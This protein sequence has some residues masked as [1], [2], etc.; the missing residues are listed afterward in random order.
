MKSMSNMF[1]TVRYILL[2]ICLVSLSQ[3]W[4]GDEDMLNPYTEFDPETGFFL[5]IENMPANQQA[6]DSTMATAPVEQ[7][8]TPVTSD[9]T[10]ESPLPAKSTTPSLLVLIGIV[11]V[12][13]G[14]IFAYRKYQ[15]TTR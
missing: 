11:V 4:A 1:V 8:M 3:V 6:Q 12:L 9:E 7:V 5:P 2:V 10:S 13:T 15:H 14:M